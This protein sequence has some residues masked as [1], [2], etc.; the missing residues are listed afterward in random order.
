[1]VTQQKFVVVF[2]K[3]PVYVLKTLKNQI[4]GEWIHMSEATIIMFP[5]FEKLKLE[6]QKLR[7]ELSM[8]FLERDELRYM[9]CRNIEMAY[10]LAL[11][12]LE[13]KVYEAEC[14]ALRLKRKSALIQ[15]KRNRQ[16][17]I[18]LPQIEEDLDAEFFEYQKRLYEQINKMNE[19]I[20]RSH[21]GI[22]SEAESKE[23]KKLYRKIVKSLHPDLHPDLSG[24]QIELFMNAVTAYENGDLQT[25]QVINEM[26]GE[27]LLQDTSQDAMT[28]LTREKER[29]ECLL[30]TVKDSIATIKSEYPYTLKEIVNSP[31]K[32]ATRR[33]ELE[34][35]L[36]QYQDMISIY[37]AR[38]EEMLR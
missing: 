5:G 34:N 27:P 23:L 38:I 33:Q 31:E 18:I 16:E 1:M 20:E 25:L 13:Y 17:K 2:V 32:I 12:S 28:Q 4:G 37:S 24:P 35:V 19:A 9:E 14:M 36:N 29:L 7:T 26:V 3:A 6:V 21:R 22:L 8:L 15:T 30:K 11:G 10:M